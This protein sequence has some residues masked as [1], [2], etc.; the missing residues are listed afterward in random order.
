MQITF[1]FTGQPRIS[2]VVDIPKL[3]GTVLPPK[4]IIQ[5]RRDLQIIM[6]HISEESKSSPESFAVQLFKTIRSEYQTL[7]LLAMVFTIEHENEGQT[8]LTYT[9]K[10]I[11]F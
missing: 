3:R 10:D 11:Q 9:S 2:L 5:A 8:V 4:T 6:S 1:A 7:V